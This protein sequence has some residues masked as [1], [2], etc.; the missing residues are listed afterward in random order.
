MKY[1]KPLFL[2]GIVTL[3][4]V[5]N[6][7]AQE[8]V[9]VKIFDSEVNVSMMSSWEETFKFAAKDTISVKV[10]VIEEDD[11]SK[12]ELKKWG[13]KAIITRNSK[14]EIDEKYYNPKESAYTFC[15]GNSAITKNKTYH[16]VIYRTTL[17]DSL[18]DFD[19]TFELDT[20]VDTS[21]VQILDASHSLAGVVGAWV[22]YKNV[23]EIPFQLPE[24][25]TGEF[26]FV[27]GTASGTNKLLAS[28]KVV[29]KTA[30][31]LNPEAILFSKAASEGL[32]NLP[33]LPEENY[34]NYYIVDGDNLKLSRA[35]QQFYPYKYAQKVTV[36]KAIVP[37][38]TKTYYYFIIENIHVKS[39]KVI[40]KAFAIKTEQRLVPK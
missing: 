4:V 36:E 7:S 9:T 6:L 39:M 21:Y 29:A 11:I 24:D 18:I 27:V 35:K 19:V 13:K 28:V 37:L 16:I 3:L 40:I 2:A 12:F 22:G 10:N 33:D 38:N 26:A 8:P 34:I 20:I 25:C 30:G 32:D 15:L 23:V 14:K 31:I 5:T 17:I 1:S